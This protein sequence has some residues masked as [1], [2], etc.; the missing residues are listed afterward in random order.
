MKIYLAK[1]SSSHLYINK[2]I[3]IKNIYIYQIF[4]KS[5]YSQNSL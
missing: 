2:K 5:N 4:N 3:N 1:L